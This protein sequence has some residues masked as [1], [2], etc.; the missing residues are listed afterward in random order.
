M[1]KQGKLFTG[2]LQSGRIS[3]IEREEFSHKF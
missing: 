2:Y 1:K 3:P